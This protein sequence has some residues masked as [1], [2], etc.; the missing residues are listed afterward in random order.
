[1]SV[2]DRIRWRLPGPRAHRLGDPLEP[3][4]C[5]DCA[6]DTMPCTNR[7]WCR[8]DGAWER[9]MV[10]HTVWAQAGAPAGY[11]CVGCLEMRLGR[12]L[13]A[14]DFID[15]AINEATPWDTP[16]LASRRADLAGER[17]SPEWARATARVALSP[18]GRGVSG[19][20]VR[21]DSGPVGVSTHAVDISPPDALEGRSQHG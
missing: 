7:P 19:G 1:M 18:F 5:E 13:T 21:P 15:V 9:Y 4:P 8:H 12:F 6:T 17:K 14:A 16:R 10:S 2:L 11:L 20:R 3:A